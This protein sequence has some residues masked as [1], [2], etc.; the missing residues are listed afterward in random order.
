MMTT[1][2]STLLSMRLE[3]FKSWKDTGAIALRP[4]TVFFGANNS[5]K[6]SLLQA[7]LLLKQTV[8]S[9]DVRVP[10]RTKV[11]KESYVDLGSVS[12]LIHHQAQHTQI[13]L[14]WQTAW[15]VAISDDEPNLALHT[16]RF[17]VKIN[18]SAHVEHLEYSGDE[19]GKQLLVRLSRQ[20][21]SDYVL[22]ARLNGQ[23][24]ARLPG[25]P[26]KAF[27][28]PIKCYGFPDEVLRAYHKAELF[29]ELSLAFEKLCEDILYLGPLREYPQRV[30]TWAG[31][32]PRDVGLKGELAIPVLIAAGTQPVYPGR[33]KKTTLQRKV[34]EALGKLGL[35]QS[36]NMRPLAA[37]NTHY[38][39]Q[40]SRL[41]DNPSLSIADL[42]FGV[43]QVLPVLVLCYY[44]PPGA[45]VIL[46][47]PEIHLHP[48]AQAGL[49]DVFIDVI[50]NRHLKL[51]IESHSEHLLRRIQRR[52]AEGAIAPED[53]AIY[54]CDLGEDGSSRLEELPINLYGDI[55]NWPKGSFGD[56]TGDL[57]EAARRRANGKAALPA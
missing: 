20:S 21:E 15:P 57:L 43:S 42:G 48:S 32:N 7:L 28:S 19:E 30:Y 51:I 44:A 36:L 2:S 16:L 55:R 45:T 26:R 10:L 17:S 6:S 3:N 13:N 39:V 38:E 29:S 37:S 11:D 1:E 35:A 23:E 25:W 9:R 18:R 56:I 49:A 46:E 41:K 22:K 27:P 12:N 4:L 53:T 40:I 24:L 31:E 50:N 8:E 52:I 47:Q 14:K 5:G 34:E 54:F 33:G